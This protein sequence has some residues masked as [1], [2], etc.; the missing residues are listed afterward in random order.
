MS[1]PKIGDLAFGESFG[2]LAKGEYHDWVWTLFSYLKSMSFAA[3]PRYWPTMQFLL[4]K[5][6][7]QS[8]IDGQKR[9]MQY[10]NDCINRR[11]DSQSER[12]DFMTP[13]MRKNPK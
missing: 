5:M 2:C 13:F 6:I 3:V 4:E 11:L 10:A 12:P 1:A 9:H 7:P 8:V